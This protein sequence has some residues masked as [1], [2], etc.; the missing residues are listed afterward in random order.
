MDFRPKLRL[1]QERVLTVYVGTPILFI[2]LWFGFDYGTNP[3]LGILI[4]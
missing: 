2:T 1:P 3:P 4:I